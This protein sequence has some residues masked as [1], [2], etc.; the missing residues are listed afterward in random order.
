MVEVPQTTIPTA[1]AGYNDEKSQKWR[2]DSTELFEHLT[3]SMGWRY[4]LIKYRDGREE[5]RW[6]RVKG[7]KPKISVEGIQD[8]VATLKPI[9]TKEVE[10]GILNEQEIKQKYFDIMSSIVVKIG[11]NA[12]KW[13]MSLIDADVLLQQI[14][15]L[16]Y[17]TLT[18]AKYGTEGKHHAENRIVKVVKSILSKGDNKGT[19]SLLG[20]SNEDNIGEE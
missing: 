18:R 19:I 3:R 9:I 4:I 13:E 16:V 14:K 17:T 15:T 11:F 12:E 20:A 8:I 10:F 7:V 5:E 2:V 1:T 6:D